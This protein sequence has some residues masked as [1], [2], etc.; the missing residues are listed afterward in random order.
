VGD[1]AGSIYIIS[2]TNHQVYLVQNDFI[3]VFVGSGFPRTSLGISLLSPSFASSH[4]K[5]L[6][7][8]DGAISGMVVVLSSDGAISGMVVGC[9]M[10]GVFVFLYI[11]ASYLDAK[12]EEFPMKKVDNIV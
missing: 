11:L 7:S 10:A 3:T 12:N 1:G 6:L 9:F 2:Y 8:S 4:K 5:S